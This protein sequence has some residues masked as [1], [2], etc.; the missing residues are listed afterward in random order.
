MGRNTKSWTEELQDAPAVSLG[1]THVP[2]WATC[3]SW[4]VLDAPCVSRPFPLTLNSPEW[5]RVITKA[6]S[7]ETDKEIQS[8]VIGSD[9][10]ERLTVE[11]PLPRA[12]FYFK[13][14]WIATDFIAFHRTVENTGFW[15]SPQT[16]SWA[17]IVSLISKH[18]QVK[19][20]TKDHWVCLS[21][22]VK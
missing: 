16:S 4:W 20:K 3:V 7:K 6:L 14:R 22:V 13:N 9:S 12:D 21:E 19:V 10:L 1:N 5:F 11:V 8:C 15:V 18:L 2:F 17:L